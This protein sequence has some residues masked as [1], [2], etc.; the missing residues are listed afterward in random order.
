VLNLEDPT[1]GDDDRRPVVPSSVLDRFARRDV[2]LDRVP[3]FTHRLRFEP[4]TREVASSDS[5][6]G[7]IDGT[8][9]SGL[10]SNPWGHGLSIGVLATESIP[11]LGLGVEVRGETHTC[12]SAIQSAEQLPD[13][14]SRD[15]SYRVTV[16]VGA[17]PS[18][19]GGRSTAALASVAAVCDPRAGR[20][21]WRGDPGQSTCVRSWVRLVSGP[22]RRRRA[23]PDPHGGEAASNREASPW[24]LTYINDRV[25][26]L[27]VTTILGFE[28]AG[29]AVVAGSRAAAPGGV[30]RATGSRVV[31][32]VGNAASG[33]DPE[34]GV[35]V[36][37]DARAIDA[38]VGTT[39]AGVATATDGGDWVR[40]GAVADRVAATLSAR[41]L[42]ATALVVGRDGD[43]RAGLRRVDA[44]GTVT[45]VERA[46]VGPAAT[47]VEAALAD[48]AVADEELPAASDAARAAIGDAVATDDPVD[49]I[50]IAHATD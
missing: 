1:V 20:H 48:R 34:A 50:A 49:A 47:A 9:D 38:V 13:G 8:M 40:L 23:G 11:R 19:T 43:G 35:A 16:R 39:T 37:G 10:P 46:V 44:D 27:T 26:R 12:S 4:A 15:R 5:V 28:C 7:T 3:Q 33:A 30:G 17:A 24:P 41:S 6:R 29:G 18:G 31:V 45:A 25:E 36:G 2:W 42:T 14:R 32:A 21:H 22:G